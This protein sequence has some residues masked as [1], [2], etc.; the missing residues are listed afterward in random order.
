[1][2]RWPKE[3]SRKTE[4]LER[5]GALPEEVDSRL[6]TEI[7]PPLRGE[8]MSRPLDFLEDFL[9]LGTVRLLP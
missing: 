7:G 6:P 8:E 9:T 2:Q 1:M 3:S 4:V 5:L